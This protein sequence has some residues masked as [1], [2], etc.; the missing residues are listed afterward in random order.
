[1]STT[2]IFPATVLQWKPQVEQASHA[3]GVPVG[4]LLAQIEDESG[5]NASAVS[6][7]GAKGLT[8]FE[9]AAAATYG[10]QFGTGSKETYSQI[11]GAA[12]YL[13]ALGYSSNPER[14]LASYNAGPDN[15]EA[16]RGYAQAILTKAEGYGTTIAGSG[17]TPP[18]T[19]PHTTSPSNPFLTN[20][21]GP[22]GTGKALD[23]LLYALLFLTG[24]LIAYKGLT[25]AAQASEP[26]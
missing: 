13:S 2:T 3:Y 14:A 15:W 4:V 17:T 24:A 16:G 5:G 9:A 20:S 12:H 18:E 23:Y 8:Q 26:S 25:H 10:V 11:M 19:I 7:A 21:S 6:S 22:R 1:M